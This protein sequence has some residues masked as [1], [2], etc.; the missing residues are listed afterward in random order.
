M[1]SMFRIATCVAVLTAGVSLAEAAQGKCSR[2]RAQGEGI[3]KEIATE[4]AKMNL[5]FRIATKGS[6]ATG[7][8]SVTCGAPGPLLWTS[9]VAQQRAC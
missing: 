2:V 6:K 5:N 8:A 3:T 1:K 7:A 9:C 4:M